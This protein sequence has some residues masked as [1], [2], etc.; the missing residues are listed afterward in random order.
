MALNK[1]YN[2]NDRSHSTINIKD[3]FKSDLHK[4]NNNIN[5]DS[6]R[7]TIYELIY[8][9]L[10]TKNDNNRVEKGGAGDGNVPT[11]VIILI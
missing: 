4:N 3:T 5:N 7:K 10:K 9:E 2:D 8:N 6:S 1:T 11:V